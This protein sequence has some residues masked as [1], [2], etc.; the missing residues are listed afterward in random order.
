MG[1]ATEI[2][3]NGYQNLAGQVIAKNALLNN[4]TIIRTPLAGCPPA[5]PT[6]KMRLAPMCVGRAGNLTMRLRN[7]DTTAHDV[8]WED[9]DSAQQGAFTAPGGKDYFFHVADGATQTH[10]IRATTGS[11]T[12]EA[13]GKG[14]ARARSR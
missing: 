1:P 10:R 4:L 5:P 8:T 6:A 9:L 14:P 2:T 7:S 13:A 12:V 3:V 11:T